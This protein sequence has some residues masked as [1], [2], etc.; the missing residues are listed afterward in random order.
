MGV[1][2]T[3]HLMRMPPG[4][5]SPAGT[6]P[7]PIKVND[8]FTPRVLSPPM[9]KEDIHFPPVSEK[10]PTLGET[11]RPEGDELMLALLEKSMAPGIVG[12]SEAE[13]EEEDRWWERPRGRK[14]EKAEEFGE[15]AMSVM[16][17]SSLELVRTRVSLAR[18][19]NSRRMDLLDVDMA[20]S[21]RSFLR[22]VGLD[23]SETSEKREGTACDHGAGS[24][25]S[26]DRGSL[27]PSR[28]ASKHATL[29]H[30]VLLPWRWCTRRRL[31]LSSTGMAGI[32][33]RCTTTLD[34]CVPTVPGTT[35]PDSDSKKG[36]YP[37]GFGSSVY[38]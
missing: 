36:T 9:P 6:R 18:S 10:E 37:S 29:A 34:W 30:R 5:S 16:V 23:A 28:H 25:S 27:W 20:V 4:E 19:T 33:P 22:P 14:A 15:E 21:C 12:R 11:E 38:L 3:A 13:A 24:D 35:V 8:G 26:P 32:T 31:R 2:A 17:G 1:R 7:D